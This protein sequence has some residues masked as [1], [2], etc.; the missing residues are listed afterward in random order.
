M[1]A[2]DYPIYFDDTKLF[3]PAKWEESFG[4]IENTY[5]TEAGTDQ[6]DV[7]RTGKLS[8]A[9]QFNCSDS[10]VTVFAQFSEANSFKL[11]SYDVKA[12]GYVT[13]TV[14]MR[15]FKPGLKDDSHKTSGTNGLYE[16]TFTL[17]EF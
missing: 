8:V 11:R 2:S 10:W 14:R 1:L 17:E 16:T 7:I 5:Q 3:Q 9:A 4:V 13:R 15:D 12:H 6:V